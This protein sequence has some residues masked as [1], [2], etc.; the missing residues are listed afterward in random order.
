MVASSVGPDRQ[1]AW[2]HRAKALTVIAHE[3]AGGVRTVRPLVAPT[4]R[5]DPP[6]R[7]GPDPHRSGPRRM[8]MRSQCHGARR[9]SR[10]DRTT[11]AIEPTLHRQLEPQRP[12]AAHPPRR[13]CSPASPAWSSASPSW[14]SSGHHRGAVRP[15][16]PTARCGCRRAPGGVGLLDRLPLPALDRARAA[17][18]VDDRRVRPRLPRGGTRAHA[19]PALCRL[20]RTSPASPPS[21]TAG[22]SASR[23]R[24]STL[25]PVIGST[26]QRPGRRFFSPE[27]AKPLMVAGCRGRRRRHLQGPGHRRAVR[28]RGPYQ[29]DVARRVRLPAMVGAVTGYVTPGAHRRHLTAVPHLRLVVR[30]QGPG[31]RADRRR[32][33]RRRR[34]AGFSLRPGPELRRSHASV[35]AHDGGTRGC[36]C[37][38]SPTRPTLPA[39]G[40][41]AIA[42]ARLR[43][44]PLG[45]SRPMVSCG[46]SVMLGSA[47]VLATMGAAARRFRH[48]PGGARRPDR[49]VGGA[50]PRTT[51]CWSWAWRRSSGGLPHAPGG[52]LV[53]RRDDWTSGFVVPA[54]VATAAASSCRRLSV[55]TSAA[56]PVDTSSAARAA[57]Q[58]RA[59]DRRAHGASR[60]PSRSCWPSTW[61]ANRRRAVPV[62]GR[63]TLPRSLAVPTRSCTFGARPGRPPPSRPSPPWPPP[64]AHH[65]AR[66]RR[67]WRRWR[68]AGTDMLPMSTAT[69]G[70]SAWSR[71]T[72]SP[73]RSSS[74]A[75]SKKPGGKPATAPD[76]GGSGGLCPEPRRPRRGR[77]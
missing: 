51:C 25:G 22:R 35:M 13:S 29:S 18:P 8:P 67:R 63:R 45:R 2:R 39:M 37:S 74:R 68:G 34:P 77:R 49:A 62:V 20:G 3:P 19:A 54:L 7:R 10:R 12:R 21:A 56:R 57:D 36:S 69:T 41:P 52:D 30:R 31:R 64:R 73:T 28:H 42:G 24:R 1:A 14:S 9:G 76:R 26:L 6:P 50:S 55:S 32:G 65:L 61:W 40:R 60:R 33:L 58:R 27:D 70:S 4:D 15:I 66:A 5:T 44:D 59:R 38:A 16:W 53:R 71:P 23:G 75:S 72:T 48:P 17:G 46:W 11:D 47:A 43:R